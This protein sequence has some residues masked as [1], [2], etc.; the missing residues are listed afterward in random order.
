MPPQVAADPEALRA[1][2]PEVALPIIDAYSNAI[3]HV[4]RWV[5]PIALL[6]FVVAWFL[7]EV[8]LRDSARVGVRDVGEGFS[9]P[10]SADR[11]VLLERAVADVLSIE[12]AKGPIVPDILAGSG[13]TL[14]RGEL[15]ALAHVY[16]LDRLLGQATPAGIAKAHQ[17]PEEVIEPIFEQ[18]QERG[19]LTKIGI[20]LSLTDSGYTQ[21]DRIRESWRR[22]LDVHLEDWDYTDPDDQVLLDRALERIAAKLLDTRE[23]VDI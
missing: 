8:P 6:G 12:R 21:L 15:W 20:R 5:V 22:W 17:V 16:L 1:L 18:V 14:S 7:K 23:T 11:V 4:F 19:Y 2:P 13:S 3:D 10:D 9:V